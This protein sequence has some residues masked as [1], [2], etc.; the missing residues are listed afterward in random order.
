MAHCRPGNT[1][2]N[3][4]I[5]QRSQLV[6][7]I[8][9]KK[10]VLC[11]GL[12]TD[13]ERIPPVFQ[14]EPDPVLA[15]NRTVIEATADLA[16]AYKIN[17]AFYEAQGSA[18]WETMRRTLDF[19]PP[20]IFTIAD[21]KRGD[22]GN[23]ADQ[24]ARAFFHQLSFDSLTLSP[25]MGE[26]SIRPFLVHEGRWA[27]ALGLT[28]N[29][30]SADFQ[31]L[32]CGGKPLYR[33]V[34]E[35]LAEWGSPQQLMFVVGATQGD[36]LRMIREWFPEHF[37]LIPGVGAQGATVKEVC[38]QA[39]NEEAGILINVS[40]GILYGGEGD[41]PSSRIRQAALGFHEDMAAFF[42]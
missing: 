1:A 28:S 32:D 10:S 35:R 38:L 25:Y 20:G 7:E 6:A 11:V 21:A 23:T 13:P 36:Q 27:I 22:I 26:D 12:D 29:P 8:R 18:G 41:D 33:I 2:I 30:G 24:Y 14:S 3:S 19:I 40:R 17:T 16:V 31:Q 4:G 37:F 34:M 9:R 39:M 5:M 15:F 42:S